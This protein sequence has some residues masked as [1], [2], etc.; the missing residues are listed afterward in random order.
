MLKKKIFIVNRQS[1][2]EFLSFGGRE[3]QLQT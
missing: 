2:L 3:N 1:R